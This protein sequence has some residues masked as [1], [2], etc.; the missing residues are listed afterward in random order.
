MI[1]NIVDRAKKMARKDSSTPGGAARGRGAGSPRCRGDELPLTFGAGKIEALIRQAEERG[2]SIELGPAAAAELALMMTH[3]VGRYQVERVY[4]SA[5]T[6]GL[7]GVIDAIRTTLT[8]LAAE[9]RAGMT[10]EDVTPSPEIVGQAV[11]FAVYGKGNRIM[12]AAAGPGG[13][14]ITAS[15]SGEPEE[16]RFWT[17]RRAGAI[18]AGL[19]TIAGAVAAIM[20]L[21]PF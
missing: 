17:W 13:T 21:R 8:E 6:G 11:Q 5:G 20:A 19:A 15:G 7:C 14:A 12:V 18:I 16:S 2:G 10:G 1:Q 9:I 4:W 3:E